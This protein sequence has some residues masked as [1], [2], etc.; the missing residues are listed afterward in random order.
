MQPPPALRLAWA[1][2]TRK[3]DC[4]S[5]NDQIFCVSA[6]S[7][8]HETPRSRLQTCGPGTALATTGVVARRSLLEPP[9]ECPAITLVRRGSVRFSEAPRARRPG[10]RAR[11]TWRRARRGD[12]HGGARRGTRTGVPGWRPR[13][14][15]ARRAVGGTGRVASARSATLNGTAEC[16]CPEA[17]ASGGAHHADAASTAEPRAA[18]TSRVPSSV[19]LVSPM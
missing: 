13:G 11:P 19:T 10:P 4:S 9:L 12:G 17:A 15:A 5:S 8:T 6:A 1:D 7:V 16:R 3:W 2:L 14:A 18:M